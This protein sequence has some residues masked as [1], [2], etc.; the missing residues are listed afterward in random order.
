MRVRHLSV[1]NFRGIRQLDWIVPDANL[2][3]LIGRGDS[4]KSTILEALRRL[5]YPQWNLSFDDAD[6]HLCDPANT[7]VIEAILGDLSRAFYD[8]ERYG[9]FL[10]GWN[11]EHLVRV[12]DPGEGLEDALRVRLKVA[13]DLEPLWSV[14]KDD[15]SAGV[16]FKASDR[17]KVGVS[18]I[19]AAS[20]RHLTWSRGSILSQL[21]ET[22]HIT[23]SL[24]TAAR[25]AKAAMEDRRAENLSKFDAV[26]AR[27]ETTARALGVKVSSSYK[28][29]LDSDAVNVRLAGLALHDG[30]MPLRQLG[31]GSKRMLTTGLQKQALD[32][33][34]ITLFDEVEVGLEPHRIA[35]L[36]QHLKADESGQYFLTTHSPV[37]LRELTVDSLHIVHTDAGQVNVVAAN[38]PAIA[39]FIQG[40]IRSGAEAFLAPKI[41]VC[42]GATEIGFLRGLDDHWSGA[43]NKS[44]FAYCGV[45]LFDAAGAS[46]IKEVAESLKALGYGVAV[47]ADSDAPNEFSDVDSQALT[48][49]GVKVTKWGGT[50]SIEERVFSD[51]PWVGVMAS[52]EAARKIMNDDQRLLDQVQ[53]Q[54][55]PGFDRNIAAWTDLPAL[56]AALGKAAKSSDWFKRQ[57]WGHAW[58]RAISC[59]LA[60][61][62]ICQTDLIRQLS[63]LRSWIDD[64]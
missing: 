39:D 25:A 17:E 16:A 61:S 52:L 41:I 49:V 42:E 27:A 21:T 47:L 24:A 28:A 8:L 26:A 58:A 53:T 37:V 46:K 4:S 60:D 63:D 38:K 12:D 22:D 36:L 30:D 50:N 29:H 40:K 20:D 14:I 59:Y 64:V 32:A 13:D 34:H 56:R 45:A 57:S 18:L 23:A 6:F 44:S 33:Q 31:L 2:L 10:C 62:A 1:R 3:C 43:E 15:E 48:D 51:L 5:F 19:G 7:I 35:R 9:H 55:G 11:T 54:F